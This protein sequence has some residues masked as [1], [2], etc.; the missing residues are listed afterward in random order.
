MTLTYAQFADFYAAVNGFAPF[1]WQERLVKVVGENDGRW[2]NVLDL[3]TSAG[4]TSALDAAVFLLALEVDG[5]TPRPVGKRAAALRTFFVVDRRIVVDEAATKARK[6][7]KLLNEADAKDKSIVGEVA[8]RLRLF[9]GGEK[10]L[11]VA[12]LRGGMYRDGSWA[13]S[14][15]QPT[16]CLSTVDQVG[17]RLLFRGYGVSPNLRAVHA[18]LVGNDALILVDEAHL[19]RPFVETLKAVEFYRSKAWAEQPVTTPFRVVVMSATAGGPVPPVIPTDEKPLEPIRLTDA[20]RADKTLSRRL[21]ASKVAELKT[22]TVAKEDDPSAR[23]TKFARGLADAAL[24]LANWIAPAAAPQ[25]EPPLLKSKKSS[26]PKSTAKVPPARPDATVIGVVVNR[27][28]TARRVCELL[29]AAVRE[30]FGIAEGDEDNA[31]ILLTGRIRPYDR[32]ELLHRKPIPVGDT[33]ERGWLPFMKAKK[34]KDKD[35][36]GRPAPPR[37]KLFVVATQ[38]VE[39]GADLSFDALV[40]EA[41]PLNA[42]RQRFGRLDRLGYRTESHAFV[43]AYSDVATAKDDPV[44]GGSMAGAWK[45][46]NDVAKKKPVDFGIDALDEAM[47][48]SPPD[49]EEVYPAVE[50]APVMMPAHV[51]DWVQTTIPPSPDPDPALFLHGPQSGPAD[52]SVVW[53]ADLTP[54]V[55][56]AKDLARQTVALV[57]PTSM[58]ALP[59]PVWHVRK[60]LKGAATAA[61]ITD[62][63]GERDSAGQVRARDV[64]SFLIWNGPDAD[65]DT[66]VSDEPDE[67][68]PGATIVVPSEYGGCDEFGWNPALLDEVTDIADD[69]SWRAKR[70][71]VL[72]VHPTLGV[73][74]VAL[75]AWA[76]LKPPLPTTATEGLATFVVTAKE[77]A[78]PDWDAARGAFGKLPALYEWLKTAKVVPYPSRRNAAS[79]GVVLV[80][81]GK[82]DGWRHPD[83]EA[84][85]EPDGAGQ[86]DDGS[87]AGGLVPLEYHCE[88]VRERVLR[89]AAALGLDSHRDTL[90]R[91]ALC[92]DAGKADPRFQQW[93][94]G[95][96]AAAAKAKFELIAKSGTESRNAAAMEKARERAGWPKRGRHEAMSV[97]MIRDSDAAKKDVPDAELLVHLVGTHHGRG[98]PL[99]PF[100]AENPEAPGEVSCKLGGLALSAAGVCRPEAALAPLSSGWVDSFWRMVGRYGYWGLAYLELLLVLAD[101]QQSRAE[102][103]GAK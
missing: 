82:K 34:D 92:H 28:D 38:T 9:S 81:K 53:R 2:P 41:A 103:E 10:A 43:M 42:L 89:F 98:R 91:A 84:D 18:G 56:D 12:V 11:H 64:R 80:A 16:I 62:L 5:D 77:D 55:L 4:K 76:A 7:A 40:T 59:L 52:V 25:E 74:G 48:Q 14:P 8:R 23:S 78:E 66:A 88:K 100:D 44:Y 65:D 83:E 72:R 63:E 20:D 54:A 101:H 47:R 1:P 70:R 57:P 32:D 96:E 85:P 26:K 95:S 58:E 39:V 87:F 51:D 61:D 93:L 17:S 27:V 75:K 73:H 60:W 86:G 71:P 67:V 79:P 21:K 90:A 94:Y 46:L 68:L 99:W 31:V 69:A 6:L 30:R 37:G 19:S 36:Y 45:W 50:H 22:V 24:E 15:T 49:P 3:P 102:Q 13:E 35:D 33:F 97:L 29:R